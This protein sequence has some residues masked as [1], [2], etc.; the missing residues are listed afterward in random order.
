[1]ARNRKYKSAAIRFGPA[2]KAFGLC[3]LLGSA[4]VGYV[5]QKNQ[6]LRL[7]EQQQKREQTL[8]EI[9]NRNEMLT[10]K[11]SEMRSADFI[12]RKIRELKLNLQ[13]PPQAQIQRLKEPPDAQLHATNATAK[14]PV[15]LAG[16]P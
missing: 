2:L 7:G 6:I 1:M 16:H 10:A 13:L 8:I 15:E 3:L 11:L 9:K 14:G 4:G 5:W 12:E